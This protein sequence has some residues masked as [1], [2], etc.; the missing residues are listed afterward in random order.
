M[1]ALALGLGAAGCTSGAEV[2]AD[3][4]AGRTEGAIVAS[5]PF[6]AQEGGEECGATAVL[7]ILSH[8]GRPVDREALRTRM[9]R[10]SVGGSFTFDVALAL[11]R[12]GLHTIERRGGSL[13]ELR[14]WLEAGRPP[15]VLLA[16][17]PFNTGL[18]HF[19]VVVGVDEGRG[20]VLVHDGARAF[21]PLDRG[22]FLERWARADRW[23]LAA[24]PPEA[25]LPRDLALVSAKDRA[26]LALLRGNLGRERLIEGRLDEAE[27]LLRATLADAPGDVR[28][29]NNLAVTLTQRAAGATDATSARVLL[30]EARALALEAVA[31][32]PEGL[33]ADCRDTL[34]EVLAAA[35]RP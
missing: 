7:V 31:R 6:V 21:A 22:E 16:L 13:D 20:V 29:R 18:K 27:G 2:R 1:A 15:V 32:A 9:V 3:L 19:A 11:R 8:A 35:S 30:A 10:P 34:R 26:R 12:A 24:I 23:S 17:R 33:V 28:A 14:G 4:E 25:T 5:V